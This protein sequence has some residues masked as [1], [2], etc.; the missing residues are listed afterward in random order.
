MSAYTG[1]DDGG[2][3]K[4]GSESNPI[5]GAKSKVQIEGEEGET[6][7][8]EDGPATVQF[9]REPDEITEDRSINLGH[10]LQHSNFLMQ[11]ARNAASHAADNFSETAHNQLEEPAVIA[12]DVS[13]SIFGSRR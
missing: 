2:K 11:H 5:I 8:P 12:P 6:N 10:S 1:L 4:G 3:G 13:D 9:D 7:S